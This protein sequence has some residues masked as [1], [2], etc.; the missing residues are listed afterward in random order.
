MICRYMPVSKFGELVQIHMDTMCIHFASK[1]VQYW[2][3]RIKFLFTNKELF[4]PKMSV[5]PE[6]SFIVLL[7]HTSAHEYIIKPCMDVHANL[8]T[9]NPGQDLLECRGSIAVSLLHNI[10]LKSPIGGSK[11]TVLNAISLNMD[12]FVCISHID[13]RSI[14]FLCHT[15]HKVMHVR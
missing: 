5:Y 10:R 3:K 4:V 13:F 7:N 12:L 2:G 11:P 15:I 8:F 14:L 6:K 1:Y 9:E